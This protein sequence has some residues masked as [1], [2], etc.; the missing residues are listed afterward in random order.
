MVFIFFLDG[1]DFQVNHFQNFGRSRSGGAEHISAS[2]CWEKEFPQ[3]AVN[4][5][6]IFGNFKQTRVLE[7]FLG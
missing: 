3:M 2:E 6:G 4:S 7:N 1:G 5:K